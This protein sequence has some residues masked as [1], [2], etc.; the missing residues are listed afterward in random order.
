[1]DACQISRSDEQPP[2]H[3]VLNLQLGHRPDQGRYRPLCS[4]ISAREINR[5]FGLLAFYR[6]ITSSSSK[7]FFALRAISAGLKGFEFACV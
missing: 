1:M 5:G 4:W 7:C 3:D 2:V 6:P